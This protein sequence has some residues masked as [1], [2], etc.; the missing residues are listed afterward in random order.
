M[1]DSSI[2]SSIFEHEALCNHCGKCCYQKLIIGR[3]VYATPFPC[4]Y[5]DVHTNQ[6]TIYERRH[7]I[8]PDCLSMESGFKHSAFPADCTYIPT[9]APKNYKPPR[10]DRDWS[11]EWL[12]FDSFAD[13]LDAPVDLRELIRARGPQAAPLHVD[14]F[15]KIQAAKLQSPL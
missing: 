2:T 15:Q 14:A 5:L 7:E 3:T 6:C 8:Y 11:G 4:K 9:M 13:D 12:D 1:P 10:E